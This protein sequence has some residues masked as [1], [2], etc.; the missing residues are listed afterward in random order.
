MTHHVVVEKLLIVYGGGFGDESGVI[1]LLIRLVLRRQQ[2]VD[3]V[4]PFMGEGRKAFVIIIVIEQQIG[5]HVI[6]TAVHIGARCLMRAREWLHPFAGE[7][8]LEQGLIFL[9]IGRQRRQ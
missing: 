3:G 1:R 8:T 6:S 9:A 4:P 7:T 2:R 5:V